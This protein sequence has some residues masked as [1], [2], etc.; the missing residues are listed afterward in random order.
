LSAQSFVTTTWASGVDLRTGRP[1]ITPAARYDETGKPFILQPG[2]QGAHS[3]HPFSYNPT[4]GLVYFSAI[5]TSTAVQSDSHFVAH[6]MSANIGL[7]FPMPASVYD[8]LKS[9]AP[10]I[11]QSRLVAW[12]PVQQRARWRS[13]VLGTIGGG[14]LTTAGGLVF[15]GTNKGRFVAYDA[16]DGRE[17]WSM[18]AQTGVVAAA[19]SFELDGEQYIAEEAGYGLARYGIGNQSRL[20]VFKLGGTATLPPA[21]PPPPPPVLNPPPSTASEQTIEGGHQQFVSHCAMCHDPPAANRS[22]FPDLRYSPALNSAA[23]FDAIVLEGA[24]QSA[25]MASFKGRLSED[26]IHAVRAYLIERANQA[27]NAPH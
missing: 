15:Q 10:R 20:L 26:E 18:E 13:D 23:A 1:R 9:N 12:D 4:T 19:S 25:G 16:D 5:E 7:V 3:W 21:A 14:T 8:D 27:K 22:V 2:A 24:L 6:P 17:L 11:A